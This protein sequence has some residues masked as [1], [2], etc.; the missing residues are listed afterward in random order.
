VEE[1]GRQEEWEASASLRKKK[2]SGEGIPV[3]ALGRNGP[4]A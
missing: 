2:T 3:A 4:L 1:G